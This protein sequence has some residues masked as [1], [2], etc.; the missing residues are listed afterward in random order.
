[1]NKRLTACILAMLTA[2]GM[3]AAP[4]NAA[5]VRETTPYGGVTWCYKNDETGAPLTDWQKID[6]TW[7]HFSEN[8][9]MDTGWLKDSGDWYFLRDSGAMKTG[10]LKNGGDWYFLRGNGAMKTGWLK[11]GGKWYYFAPSGKMITGLTEI[12]GKRY[13]FNDLP[14]T[15]WM[16]TGFVEREEGTRYF[17]PADES[18]EMATGWKEIGEK[19]YYF[20]ENGLMATGKVKIDGK[21]YRFGTDG[22]LI[23]RP[24]VNPVFTPDH[25][26]TPAAKETTYLTEGTTLIGIIPGD[27]F[28]GTLTV[29]SGITTIGNGSPLTGLDRVTSVVLSDSVTEILASAFEGKESL[30]DSVTGD[31]E[32]YESA[33]NTPGHSSSAH[34]CKPKTSLFTVYENGELICAVSRKTVSGTLHVPAKVKGKEVKAISASAFYS[35]DN[36]TSVTL[37]STITSIGGDAF[38]NCKALTSIEIPDSVTTIGDYTFNSCTSLKTIKIPSSVT[39]IGNSA[40]KSCTSLTSVTFAEGSTLTTIG[41][42]AF[43]NCTSLKTIKIP[44]SVTSIG[45]GAF[46]GCSKLTSIEI[47]SLVTTIGGET[48]YNCEA[49]T[50][51]TFADASKLTSIQNNAFSRCTNLSAVYA[52]VNS[53]LADALSEIGTFYFHAENDCTTHPNTPSHYCKTSGSLFKVDEHGILTLADGVDKSKLP[54][55]LVIP[56]TVNGKTVTS[57]RYE[58]FSNCTNLTS[59]TIPSTVISIGLSAFSDCSALTS[60]TFADASKLTSIGKNAFSGCT[61]LSAVYASKNSSLAAALSQIGTFYFHAENDCTD[62]THD[63]TKSHYCKTSKTSN[64]LF[65]VDNFGALTLA[66][67]VDKSEISGDIEIPATVNGQ[68]VTSIGTDAFSDCSALTSITLPSTL[69][70]IGTRAFYHSALTSIEIPSSVTTIDSKAFWSCTSLTSVTFAEGSTLT[71][72]GD[73]AFYACKALTSIT[74]PSTL[75]SIGKRAFY[76][77][78]ALTSIE[79]PSSVTSIGWYA[80]GGCTSLTSVTFADASTLTSISYRAFFDCTSLS[81][82][83]ASKNDALASALSEIGTFYFHAENDCTDTNH[84]TTKSHYCKTSNSLFKFDEHGNLTV[85]KSEL[86]ATLEIPSTVDG[87]T[88]TSIPFEAFSNCTNLTSVTIP[89]TVTSVN[90]RAFQ[91][92]SG[93]TEITLPSS[94]TNLGS[95]VFS[96]CTSL[97]TVTIE[98]TSKLNNVGSNL[99]S[100]CTNLEVVYVSTDDT[101]LSAPLNSS[102]AGTFYFHDSENPCANSHDTMKP[103]YCKDS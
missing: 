38:S 76:H 94:V 28:D 26:E 73:D 92:C 101:R 30:L 3:T 69:T 90:P 96:G 25:V 53:S 39:T 75:T 99:F 5:W 100:G 77:C 21:T 65:K 8:G 6:G 7:Y 91:N 57:I 59:V 67:G 13:F 10:W 79:I 102:G 24:A 50:S 20:D 41:H 62:T 87:Q 88:V 55:T 14:D 64:S 23:E 81:A 49:L 52:S 34:Y 56:S 43:N 47:P 18:G 98:S 86:P 71:S 63:T 15:D 48:F 9:T 51:V 2:A 85:D 84:D 58:A 93:L 44:S 54:A 68:T 4:V 80:F 60:V 16:L 11:N 46:Y 70:S 19:T 78:F 35:H 95:Y 29:P 42:F 61:S 103:H 27:N 66:N 17:E 32:Y 83:Y 72:I 22:A 40:F 33:C 89:S 1:M 74:L 37:P 97:K 36:L 45:Y 82:V 31:F 12:G